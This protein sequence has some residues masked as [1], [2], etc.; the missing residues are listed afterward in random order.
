M[1]NAVLHPM[2][3]LLLALCM[4]MALPSHGSSEPLVEEG[5]KHSWFSFNK[6]AKTNPSD[7]MDYA[8]ELLRAGHLRK[9]GKAFRAL[10]ITWPGSKETPLA[11]WAYA[12]V[13]D[14]RGKLEAAFEAYQELLDR[15]GGRFPEYEKVLERQFEIAKGVMSTRRGILIF[16]GFSAPERAIPLFESIVRNGPRSPLAPE[17][18]YLIGE[19]HEKNF[20]YDLAVMA[21]SA[22]LH[23]YPLSPFAEKASFARARALDSLSREYPKDVQ[24]LE[25]AWAANNAFL[26]AYPN[27]EFEGE[28]TE[29]RDRLFRKR[30]KTSYDIAYYYDAIT[31][32]PNVALES[33]RNFVQLYP[34]SEWTATARERIAELEKTVSTNLTEGTATNE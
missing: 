27:S 31:K 22:T 5:K 6:P 3:F 12:R 29:I 10:V 16:G 33:Y 34:E 2:R 1:L 11:Q 9:A 17:A 25:E 28:A 21:Y 15:H 18:Q 14:E 8:Q 32:R 4:I 13:L 23:R 24:A 26:R 20:E 19:A 30:A 7:Q